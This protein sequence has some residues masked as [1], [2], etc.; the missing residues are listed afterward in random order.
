MA[1]GLIF[2]QDIKSAVSREECE[3]LAT[4]ATEKRVLEVGSEYG[5]S[6]IALASTA[7]Q[8]HA[9]DWHQ[10]DPQSG[11]KNSLPEFLSNLDHY[12]LRERVIVHLG[13][14]ED[15]APVMRSAVFDLAFIDG[16]HS[17]DA[18]RRDFDLALRVMKPGGWMVFH[19]TDQSQVGE[20]L[21][22][23]ATWCRMSYARSVGTLAE[24]ITMS[25]P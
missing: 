1:A 16:D 14:W 5:R 13:R 4:L 23:M 20:T 25:Q 6:T 11:F 15:V 22:Q 17:E 7:K 18:V 21:Q 3:R 10:G 2:A 24:V 9:V 8:V 19:D 12:D